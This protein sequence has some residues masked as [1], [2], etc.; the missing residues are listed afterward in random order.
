MP[1]DF[2]SVTRALIAPT[3]MTKEVA[4]EIINRS[5]ARTPLQPEE[6]Y[7]FEG[8]LSGQRVDTYQTRMAESTMR[9][10]LTDFNEGR[11][12]MNSHRTGGFMDAELPMGR[13]FAAQI[14]GQFMAT[15]APYDAVDGASL[16]T[17]AYLQRGL[18]LTGVST[19]D[20]IRGIDGGTI[21]DMSIGFRVGPDGSYR[22]S[23]CGKDMRDWSGDCFHV[24]GVKY[25]QGRA[26]AW[27]EGGRGV[28]GSLVFAHSTPQ[29][30]IT[31]AIRM[32][33]TGKLSRRDAGLL[34]EE[35]GVRIITGRGTIVPTPQP[36]T[37][38]ESAK[39]DWDAIITTL[40]AVDAPL[41][42]RLAGKDEAGKVTELVSALRGQKGQI[43][44]LSPR[45]LLG[46]KY[47]DDLV[48]QNRVIAENKAFD[49]ERYRKQLRASADV[50]YIKEEIASW[51]RQAQA[52]MSGSGKLRPT[53]GAGAADAAGRKPAAKAS[54]NSYRG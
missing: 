51:D 33:E 19:D 20:A 26:F 41:A 16:T 13:I 17:W 45:A 24:P 27:V 3:A 9:N 14:D 36:R 6:A 44:N 31:K 46:D 10:Y 34:E 23:I 7:V 52:V 12:L 4:M 30:V 53:G 8:R 15:S 28:E 50:D 25:E 18:N 38:K 37:I 43:D 35:L 5:H 54:P 47:L 2:N 48:D 32:V 40:K 21:N 11:A 1:D 39:V 42:E 49:G 22:C 29:A